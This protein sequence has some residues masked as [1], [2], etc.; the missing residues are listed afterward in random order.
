MNFAD[1]KVLNSKPSSRIRES[2]DKLYSYYPTHSAGSARML[3]PYFAAVLDRRTKL[4]Y[5]RR[6]G[7]LADVR[8]W[9]DERFEDACHRY[10]K[11]YEKKQSHEASNTSEFGE[12][13]EEAHVTDS[14]LL[15]T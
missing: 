10:K 12:V 2:H 6:R 4:K 9:V 8:T 7:F 13:F 11:A 3:N 5:L 1:I 14:G 15:L